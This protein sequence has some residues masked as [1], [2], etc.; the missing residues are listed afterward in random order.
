MIELIR[1]VGR[2]VKY[3]MKEAKVYLDN[4]TKPTPSDQVRLL[5][6][7][8]GRT[9]STLL[10]SLI[11]STGH[12]SINGELL[13]TRKIEILY[14]IPYIYGLTKRA[15]SEN[16][17]FHVKVYQLTEDRKRPIDPAPFLE[18]LFNEG[19]NIIYLRRKNKVKHALSNVVANHRGHFHKLHDGVERF[20]ITVDLDYFVGQVNNRLRY[21]ETERKAL[22]NIDYHEVVYED[23]LEKADAHQLTVNKILDYLT[24]EQREAITKH[25]KV[26]TQPLDDLIINYDEFIDCVTKHGWQEFL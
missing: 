5:I 9:G 16:F 25:R 26:N 4:F 12:F 13:N 15:Q 2:P 1:K 18:R 22:A 14:P 11:C 10:E 21:E 23:D 17:I 3:R 20:N 7:G 19:W 8:Q 6:F 24:L